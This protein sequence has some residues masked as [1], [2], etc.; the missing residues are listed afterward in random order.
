MSDFEYGEGAHYGASSLAAPIFDLRIFSPSY[1]FS[2]SLDSV[3]ER[4]GPSAL[5]VL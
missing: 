1:C 3:E 4:F 5:L 2:V